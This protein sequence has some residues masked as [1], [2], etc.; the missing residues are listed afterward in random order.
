MTTAILGLLTFVLL[1]AGLTLHGIYLESKID[2]PCRP[3]SARRDPMSESVKSRLFGRRS[4]I[5]AARRGVVTSE[6]RVISGDKKVSAESY[7]RS[8]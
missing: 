1:T 3:S 2:L 4:S 8:S 5:P 6:V 7:E